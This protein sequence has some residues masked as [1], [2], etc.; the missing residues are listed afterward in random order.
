MSGFVRVSLACGDAMVDATLPEGVPSAEIVPLLATLFP[1]EDMRAPGLATVSGVRLAPESSLGG[2]GVRDGD[3]LIVQEEISPLEAEASRRHDDVAIAVAEL[4]ADR[5]AQSGSPSIAAAGA[6]LA[7]LLAVLT[8][9]VL[10][11][12]APAP[13]TGGPGVGTREWW[14]TAWWADGWGMR[15]AAVVAAGG[16]CLLLLLLHRLCRRGDLASAQ[17]GTARVLAIAAPAMG[18]LAGYAAAMP[19]VASTGGAEAPSAVVGQPSPGALL[20]AGLAGLLAAGLAWAVGPQARPLA[21]V[22]AVPSGVMALIG[23]LAIPTGVDSLAAPVACFAVVALT[24]GMGSMEHPR[25][26]PERSV[27]RDTGPQA[28]RGAP[29]RAIVPGLLLVMLCLAPWLLRAGPAGWSL[30]GAG[31]L[32]GGLGTLLSLGVTS[33]APTADR[34][35]RLLR[36]AAVLMVPPLTMFASGLA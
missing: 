20:A 10:S 15:P 3:L 25:P 16:T 11:T 17:Q 13:G 7:L 36:A 14:T 22:P 23:A 33:S 4:L 31:L 27:S 28:W 8:L 21:L 1:G 35:V 19:V 12:G 29:A 5:R 32:A 6:C 26:V 2:Q 9:A 34:G 24:L 30:L 18:A